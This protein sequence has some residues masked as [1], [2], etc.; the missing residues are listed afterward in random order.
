MRFRDII[1]ILISISNISVAQVSNLNINYRNEFFQTEISR[2]QQLMQ[3]EQQITENQ[4]DFDVTYYS[5]DL[6]PDP[7]T[8]TL[9][10]IVEIVGEV[11]STT[12]NHVELNFWDG[13]NITDLHMSGSPGTQLNYTRSN[14]ILSINLDREYAQGE[15][16]SI[17]VAY[18]G[19]PQDSEELG[20]G[21]GFDTH[22]G[23]S[24]IWSFSQPWGARVWWPCKDVPSDKADSVDIRVTVPNNLIVASNGS[25]IETTTTGN[26]KTYWWHEKY[27]IATYLVSLAIYP[28]EV[29][30]DDYVYNNGNDIM[31]IHFYTFPGNYQ[32]YYDIN[33]KL[34]DMLGYFSGIFGQYP[35]IDEKYGHADFTEGG[36][37]EHQTLPSFH[38]YAEW[39]YAH[40][41]AH[42]WW[43]DMVTYDSWHHTWL[44]EGLAVYAEALWHEHINGSGTAND[45]QMNKNLYFGA[46]TI[47][48]E[49]FEN[50]V[51]PIDSPL[52]PGLI[53]QKASWV[54]HMLRHV[55]GDETF[56]DM[57]KAYHSDPELKYNNAS[58]EDFQ[59]V[60]EDVSGLDLESFFHQWIYTEFFPVYAYGY[61]AEDQGKNKGYKID[62]YIDQVQQNT[63][64]FTMPI[65]IRVTTA[66]GE[67]T[68]VVQNSL[69]SEHYEL[70]VD[71]EPLNVELDPEGWILKNTKEKLVNP[72]LDKGAL[73]VNGLQWSLGSFITD[74]YASKSFWGNVEISFWDLFDEPTGGYP[75]TLPDPIGNGDLAVKTMGDYSTLIWISHNRGGDLEKWNSVPI[76]D[77]VN[78]GGNVVLVTQNGQYFISEQLS[79]YIGIEWDESVLL[80]IA[81]CIS[82]HP[83]LVDIEL[84]RTHTQISL[85][86][87]E[88]TNPNAQLLFTETTSFD[89]TKGLGVWSGDEKGGQFVYIGLRPFLVDNDQMQTNMEY[90]L[91]EFMDEPTGIEEEEVNILP[92]EYKLFQNYPNPFNPSTTIKYAIS[93]QS[94]VRLT[95]Y[96]LLG[97]AIIDLVDEEKQ[98]GYHEVD[99]NASTLS[100]GVYFYQLSTEAVDGSA[101]FLNTK[102]LV[103]LK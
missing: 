22:E 13:M 49:D 47:Y 77:Y 19:R 103:V 101:E 76:M 23:Q 27:P 93:N 99:F 58:I 56:F 2:L 88:L 5:L 87:T 3:C 75:A 98:A 48:A 65:D 41:L 46:G 6:T 51:D 102:K 11:I 74:A 70:F 29:H 45:Y 64:L 84:M 78:A 94:V 86:D 44:S 80:T 28:Y 10:G 54:L 66:A 7:V 40:E 59:A 30:Y 15:I 67:E 34:K 43:G 83:S 1:L 89:E 52:Y 61:S 95:V 85:F 26:N 25:L 63:G 96:N 37:M 16:F 33:M 42:Q 9:T 57:I 69:A 73:L 90:I 21:F 79:D 18:N 91:T 92:K 24:M 50:F 35:F 55:V 14:D 12:L 8:S 100:S 68:F 4:E 32:Q 38:F 39:L 31:K 17:T 53:Y 71:D 82:N 81:E 97:E 36:A 20:W 60:C 62:L 72:A